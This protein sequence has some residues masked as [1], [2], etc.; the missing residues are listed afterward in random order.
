LNVNT[1]GT[2]LPFPVFVSTPTGLQ[3]GFTFGNRMPVNFREI[4]KLSPLTADLSI[5]KDDNQTTAV[6]GTTITYTIV[7]TNNGPIGVNGVRVTDLFPVS[8]NGFTSVTFK[9]S[10][11][12]P[13]S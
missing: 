3:G 10:F 8:P 2:T 9:R 13:N 5:T 4:E 12:S 11:S 6:P 7:A 1:N